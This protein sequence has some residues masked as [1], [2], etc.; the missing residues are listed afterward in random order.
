MKP[1]LVLLVP[2]SEHREFMAEMRA[3]GVV[4]RPDPQFDFL[5]LEG[6]NYQF[7]FSG[8]VIEDF[9][10]EELEEASQVAPDPSAILM[11]YEDAKS[12]KVLARR[13]DGEPEWDWRFGE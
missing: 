4:N 6:E 2:G 7:S 9:S 1:T 5:E 3:L 10:P 13:M 11:E 8:C 12:A